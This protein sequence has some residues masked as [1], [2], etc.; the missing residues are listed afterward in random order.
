MGF[1]RGC[2]WDRCCLISL[3]NISDRDSGI[4][5][6]PSQFANDTRLCGVISMLEGSDAIQRGPDSLENWAHAKVLDFNKARCKVQHLVW[7]N[8]KLR[9]SLGREW[10]GS[11][12][13]KRD[14]R[15]LVDE[16]L[17][18]TQPRAF[19]AQKAK[20]V[21]GCTQSSVGSR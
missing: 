18:M 17:T 14:L 13:G 15:L 9:E 4:E 7:G 8:P 12:S 2:Y 10:I 21:L 16:Q 11:S 6:S 19:A 5:C 20:N 3:F 1:L